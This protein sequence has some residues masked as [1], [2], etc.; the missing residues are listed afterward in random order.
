MK[1]KPQTRLCIKYVG[2]EVL[3]F[4]LCLFLNVIL[5]LKFDTGDALLG[6]TAFITCLACYDSYANGVKDSKNKSDL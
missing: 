3:A 4:A 6:M 2:L 5:K 1:L